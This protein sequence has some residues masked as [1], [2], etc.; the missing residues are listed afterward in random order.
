MAFTLT[1]W[2]P[3]DPTLAVVCHWTKLID[4]LKEK[5]NEQQNLI[6]K[7]NVCSQRHNWLSLQYGSV[8]PFQKGR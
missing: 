7:T 2:S 8:F 3:D 5:Q 1:L 4:M 6:F